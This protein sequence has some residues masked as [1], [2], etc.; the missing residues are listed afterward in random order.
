MPMSMSYSQVTQAPALE[1]LESRTMLAAN[2]FLAGHVLHVR[3]AEFAANTIVVKNS[4]DGTAVDVSIV[5]VTGKN[6]T[7]SFA[8]S[9]PKSLGIDR[10]KIDGGNKADAITVDQTAS[11]FTIKTL[12][13]GKGGDDVI[14][15]GDGD[16]VISGKGGN[17]VIHGMGGNDLIFGRHGNDTLTGD[18]G[19]DTMWGGVGDDNLDGG[20][21]DDKLGGIVGHNVLTGG[22]GADTF[23][24]RSLSD[25]PSNDYNSAED[26]L[27]VKPKQADKENEKAE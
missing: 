26:T 19:N 18:E 3:G 1:T 9:F 10:V 21:G 25:N 12:I 14:T 8:T 2:A 6:I 7:K 16:D 24:V 13:D 11:P 4:T 22:A 5:S 27:I 15:G 17:D 20:N 23:V